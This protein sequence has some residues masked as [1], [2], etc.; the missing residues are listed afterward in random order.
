MDHKCAMCKYLSADFGPCPD[1]YIKEC[2]DHSEF[3]CAK[4]ID[5]MGLALIREYIIEYIM[6]NDDIM[7]NED[8]RNIVDLPSV[9]A[10]LYEV[11][12]R[13]IMHEP[14]DYMFHWANKS[15]SNVDDD[16]FIGGDKA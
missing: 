14:Y 3:E 13:T 4:E 10:S 9:I 6:R 15:G 16:Y 8:A 11:L 7:H 12:H 1:C 5:D 2:E